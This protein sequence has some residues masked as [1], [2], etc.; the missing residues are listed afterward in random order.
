[1]SRLLGASP[2]VAAAGILG[3]LVSIAT[4]G[5]GLGRRAPAYPVGKAEIVERAR[6]FVAAS[7]RAPSGWLAAADPA[8]KQRDRLDKRL[9]VDEVRGASLSGALPIEAW[10]VRFRDQ[11]LFTRL[12]EDPG[13]IAVTLSET[14]E[15]LS[16]RFHEPTLDADAPG[17]E[18]ARRIAAEHLV[19][20][21]LDPSA[22]AEEGAGEASTRPAEEATEQGA[23]REQRFVWKR[24]DPARP[25]VAQTLTATVTASGLTQFARDVEVERNVRTSEED[26]L[27]T[28][29]ALATITILLLAF[30]VIIPLAL[31]MLGLAVARLVTRNYISVRRALVLGAAYAASI[32]ASSV[33]TETLAAAIAIQYPA[34]L[35]GLATFSLVVVCA[36][37]VGEV[38]GYLA[39]GPRAT[40]G[41]VAVLSGRFA[42]RCVAREVLEGYCWGWVFLGVLM[43]A[44]AL[45]GATIGADAVHREPQIDAFDNHPPWL[46]VLGAASAALGLAGFAYGFAVPLALRLLKH[47]WLAIPVAAIP[48]ALLAMLSEV[49]DGLSSVPG[50][51][52]IP[53]ALASCTL[54]LRRGVLTATSGAFAFFA[55]YHG[56]PLLFA[57]SPWDVAAGGLGLGLAALPV[58]AAFA[59]GPRAPDIAVAEAPPRLDRYLKEVRHQ[60]ELTIA[61]RVQERLLPA[62]DPSL[63]GLG[64]A[65]VCLPAKE[66]GGDYFDYFPRPDG[67]FGIAVGDVSGK[68]VPA[69]FFMA[70]TKGY[71]EMAAEANEP[72][73]ALGRVNGLLRRRLTKSTFVTMVYAVYDPE[74]RTLTCASAGHNPPLLVRPGALPEF[75]AVPGV[76]LGAATPERFGSLV[77]SVAIPLERGDAVVFYTDGVT[78]ARDTDRDEFGEERLVSALSETDGGATARGLAEGLV[79]RVNAFRGAADQHDDITVVV[80]KVT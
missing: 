18:E 23:A 17:R 30:A 58:I 25:G 13:G 66:I 79:A 4:Y 14:G 40:E 51:W 34:L 72:A 32:L 10:T 37:L 80:V 60:E 48:T 39:L 9:G 26:R 53:F 43:A 7:G 44:A 54:V 68:G 59:L 77:G 52:T 55:F 67:R 22:Y 56:I 24:P 69:A 61:H 29:V 33:A 49:Q 19:R 42:V 2:V 75:V 36:W 62:E 45:V 12:E 11:V 31:L 57:G 1:V 65:G 6:A 71:M 28:G 3:L 76:A 21:G 47:P 5:P 63:D 41:M 64:V 27:P 8:S 70:L 35:I 16:A 20:L 73:A 46:F 38:D 50:V 78:E 74:S 15:V